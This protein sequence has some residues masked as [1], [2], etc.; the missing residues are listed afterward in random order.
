MTAGKDEFA[1]LQRVESL[2]ALAIKPCV[3]PRQRVGFRQR[4]LAQLPALPA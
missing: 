1:D 2:P 4:A 3:E